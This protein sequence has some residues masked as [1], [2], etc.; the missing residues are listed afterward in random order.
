MSRL[1]R[2]DLER[3]LVTLG[4]LTNKPYVVSM[5]NGYYHVYVKTNGE[6]LISGSLRGCYDYVTA[7]LHGI[8]YTLD[9]NL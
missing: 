2:S 4:T 6:H 9:N 1:N 3:K 5:W 8:N 7:F